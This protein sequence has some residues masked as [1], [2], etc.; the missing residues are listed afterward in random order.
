MKGHRKVKEAQRRK[1]AEERTTKRNAL[2]DQEQ[3]DIIKDRRGDSKKE[4][5]RLT[6][7]T[8]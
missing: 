3:L 8:D 6:K 7:K 4:T 1:E 5:A 2:T